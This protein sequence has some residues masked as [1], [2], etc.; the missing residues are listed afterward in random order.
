MKK[1]GKKVTYFLVQGLSVCFGLFLGGMVLD[2]LYRY[3]PADVSLG[4]Q[5]LMSLLLITMVLIATFLN[6][7]IHEAGHLVCG[8]CS[9]YHFVSFRAGN[10]ML[11]RRDGKLHWCR[12]SYPGTGGQCAMGPPEPVDGKIPVMLFNFGG[13]IANLLGCVLYLL[14]C[15]AF[16]GYP[17]V[18]FFFRIAAAEALYAA[19]TNGIPVQSP[20]ITNDGYN[21]LALGTEPEAN[22]AFREQMRYAE[23][24]TEGYR[25]GQMPE[26]WFTVPSDEQ[27]QQRSKTFYGLAACARMMDRQEYAEADALMAHLTAIDSA[28]A[29]MQ[30]GLLDLERLYIEVLGENRPQQRADL[31]TKRTTRVR[32]VFA[33]SLSVQR[34]EYAWALLVQRDG[35]KAAA[36]LKRFEKLARRYPYPGDLASEREQLQRVRQQAAELAVC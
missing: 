19:L 35:K 1:F 36:A 17:H 6:I 11:V 4:R 7:L 15:A 5:Y 26:E 12:Y 29:E 23:L 9:G 2:F 25:L 10:W 24:L 30:K 20:S 33:R 22:R 16:G 14:L 27:M 28:L 34:F 3:Y 13:C 31:V 21:A 32:K 8:L 18:S